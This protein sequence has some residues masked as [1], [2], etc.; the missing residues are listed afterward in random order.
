MDSDKLYM[1]AIT[2]TKS[3]Y[4]VAYIAQFPYSPHSKIITTA[5][6]AGIPLGPFY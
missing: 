3:L 5:A 4:R 6:D 2:E 1:I